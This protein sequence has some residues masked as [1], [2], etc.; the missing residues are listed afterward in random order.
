MDDAG[1]PKVASLDHAEI[2][3]VSD[4]HL[5]SADR[6][7]EEAKMA[8]FLEFLDHVEATS[9][10]FV[11]GGDL[12]D[13]WFEFRHVIP[14][15]AFRAVARIERLVSAGVAVYFMGGNHDYWVADFF[16]RELGVTVLETGPV[17]AMQGRR[18]FL[19]HGDGIAK[20]DWGYRA[21]KAV[22]RNPFVIGALRLVH[23][24][25]LLSTAYRLSHGSRRMTE[26]WEDDPERLYREIALPAFARGADAAMVGHYHCP[27]H[28]RRDGK[29]FVIIGDW[30]KHASYVRLRNGAFELHDFREEKAAGGAGTTGAAGVAGTAAKAAPVPAARR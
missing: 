5:G 26:K 4:V 15:A 2:V 7:A 16:T 18:L 23:P 14:K 21:L 10:A 27:T 1:P 29:D 11:I 24:D 3:F 28:F 17:R 25:L 12:F 20:G 30:V 6:A 13:F 8:L 9:R 19:A 22:V